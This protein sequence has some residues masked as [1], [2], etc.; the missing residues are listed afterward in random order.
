MI[1]NKKPLALLCIIII[2]IVSV[3]LA[4]PFPT[5]WGSSVECTLF[6]K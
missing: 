5:L 1:Q 6:E 4:P 3:F 2:N